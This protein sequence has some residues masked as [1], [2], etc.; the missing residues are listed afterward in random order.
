MMEL[1]RATGGFSFCPILTEIS[2]LQSLAMNHAFFANINL[3]C[4]VAGP[5]REIL[6]LSF[7]SALHFPFILPFF[8]RF[9]PIFLT[10]F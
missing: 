6:I 3:N 5:K 10:N 4:I 2:V 8:D 1:I 7:K 9:L